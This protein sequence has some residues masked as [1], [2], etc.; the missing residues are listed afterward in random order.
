MF[1]FPA[2][3]RYDADDDYSKSLFIKAN[4]INDAKAIFSQVRAET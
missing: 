3:S 2:V 1:R 4:R